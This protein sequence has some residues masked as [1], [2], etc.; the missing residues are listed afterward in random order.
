M[1]TRLLC[2]CALLALALTG[3]RDAPTTD[4]GT[5]LAD[6]AQYNNKTVTVEGTVGRSIGVLGYGAYE[7]ADDTGKL[8]VISKTGGAPRE[9][10]KVVVRGEFRNAF[11]L[12]T[13]T[14]A[15]IM[16][17]ERVTRP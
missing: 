1:K 15:A 13:T 17:E 12:G 11:T 10:S 6:P 9:G 3:C 4:I 14:G 7:L 5:L 16:E 8:P 2:F